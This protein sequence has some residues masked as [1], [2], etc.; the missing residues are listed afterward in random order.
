MVSSMPK[1]DPVQVQPW[2][3]LEKRA[4]PITSEPAAVVVQ[5]GDVL[6]DGSVAERDTQIY[7][8]S[9]SVDSTYN[10]WQETP[11]IVVGDETISITASGEWRVVGGDL[12][13]PGGHLGR[14]AYGPPSGR[15]GGYLAPGKFE[16]CLL[17][18][19]GTEFVQGFNNDDET[20]LV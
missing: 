13:C 14:V 1:I 15:D 19:D 10:G 12:N 3:A 18:M 6:P 2:E 11:V 9:V 16:G 17:V 8:M 7:T 20:I 5:R 4:T